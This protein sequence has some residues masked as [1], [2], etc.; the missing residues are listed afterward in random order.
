MY[1]HDLG[2]KAILV[3]SI[4]FVGEIWVTLSRKP[5]KRISR[6]EIIQKTSINSPWASPPPRVFLK[7]ID[8]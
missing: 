8:F 3:S 5:K 6:H 4:G 2:G 1:P 7:T